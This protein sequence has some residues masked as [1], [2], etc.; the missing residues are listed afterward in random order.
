MSG[1]N[2][3]YDMPVLYMWRGRKTGTELVEP[4]IDIETPVS[5]GGG[6]LITKPVPRRPLFEPALYG[7]VKGQS[8]PT[9]EYLYVHCQ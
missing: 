9:L 8:Y 4:S 6:M 5:A 3:S 1:S 2:A 7:S